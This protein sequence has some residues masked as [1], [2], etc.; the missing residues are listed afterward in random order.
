MHRERH[1]Q[2]EPERKRGHGA[3]HDQ[4]MR[5]CAPEAAGLQDDDVV[6]EAKRAIRTGDAAQHDRGNRIEKED[7]Q[8]GERNNKTEREEDAIDVERP[9]AANGKRHGGPDLRPGAKQERARAADIT[10]APPSCSG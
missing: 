1:Q 5:R 10:T 2:A 7:D 6:A 4:A 8:P 9:G 3:A